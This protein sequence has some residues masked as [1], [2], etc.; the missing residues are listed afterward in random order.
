MKKILSVLLCAALVLT[1]TACGGSA[2]NTS[3]MGVMREE[4]AA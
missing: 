1:L 2:K 4:A 3:A